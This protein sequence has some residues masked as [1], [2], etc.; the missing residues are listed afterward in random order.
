MTRVTL[1][2][3]IQINN[4]LK[5]SSNNFFKKQHFLTSGYKLLFL[6]KISINCQSFAFNVLKQLYQ[7]CSRLLSPPYGP[8]LVEAKISDHNTPISE[9]LFKMFI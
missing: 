3:S 6:V 8:S 1:M 7:Y 2:N 9:C 5:R 4:N